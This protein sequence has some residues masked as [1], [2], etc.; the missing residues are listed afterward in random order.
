[1]SRVQLSFP[2]QIFMEDDGMKLF[3]GLDVS[4]AK[5]A[6]CVLTEHGKII[7]E[8]EVV[9]EP[10]PLISLLKG[11]EGASHAEHAN[12]MGTPELHRTSIMSAALA[13]DHGPKH[14]PERSHE[15]AAR[16]RADRPNRNS[17][18]AGSDRL[19]GIS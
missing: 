15:R 2:H 4:L 19:T 5:T 1:M 9:S 7:E 12:E 16:R 13:A 3:V 17:P 14:V 11:L 18:S 6:V 10:E 8:M